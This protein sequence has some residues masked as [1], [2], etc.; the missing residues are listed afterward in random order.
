[1]KNL[2]E[3][4]IIKIFQTKFKNKNFVSEDVEFLKLEKTSVI[5]KIDTLV[6]ST[7]VPPG[8]KK[9]LVARK[10]IVACVSDF[11]AK[12]VKPKYG[13]ISI[14]I[15]RR[16]S[17]KD[18]SQL[19]SGITSASKEFGIKIIGGDTNEGKELSI[20]VCII[21]SSKKIVK[22]KGAQNDDIIFVTGPFGFTAAG[23]K[24]LLKKKKAS[25]RLKLKAK[26][27]V[28]R[29]KTRLEF[30]LLSKKLLTSSMDSSDGLSTSLNEM[31]KQS[32]KKFVIT[33]IPTKPDLYE[34]AKKNHLNP[35]DLVFNG[36]EE[37]EIIFTIPKKNR[38]KILKIARN[39]K[40]P[41]IEIGYVMQG[42]GVKLQT[43][44]QQI[45]IRDGGWRH[46][47]S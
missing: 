15:P 44:K 11:A 31:S 3:E 8:F 12:G 37:Y 41:I 9:N 33:K 7:D 47:K 29:P 13:I 2:N 19:A 32:Q 5:V 39:L 35:L 17:K 46:F 43:D 45:S 18:V 24:I 6:E 30:G 40:I 4:G 10:S 34:F 1:M 27:S 26:K 36:G 28:Y 21:G 42:T 14:T 23:L 16:F 25:R 38:Q 20:S 22:R